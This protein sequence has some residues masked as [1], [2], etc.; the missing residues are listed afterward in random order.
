[1]TM[2]VVTLEGFRANKKIDIKN[3]LIFKGYIVIKSIN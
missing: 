2:K 3:K 1:M